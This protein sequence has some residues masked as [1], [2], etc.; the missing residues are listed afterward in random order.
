[1]VAELRLSELERASA[2]AAE[3]TAA[4]GDVELLHD[5]ES[6]HGSAIGQAPFR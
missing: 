5:E 2:G 6:S 3:S 1:M 4:E